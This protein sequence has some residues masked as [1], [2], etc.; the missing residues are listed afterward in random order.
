ME[1]NR[2]GID[3]ICYTYPGTTIPQIAS[4]VPHL[5][6]KHLVKEYQHIML[7]C[8]GNDA[9]EYCPSTIIKNYER[10]IKKVRD[11]APHARIHLS[12]IPPRRN[13]PNVLEKIAKINTYIKNR[14]KWNDN[15][16]CI[17]VCP[18][19]QQMYKTDRV[20]F[21]E[22]GTKMYGVN[23]ARAIVNFHRTAQKTRV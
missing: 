2:N 5:M 18:T 9:E 1:L 20:H 21:S 6:P 15:V 13:N 19:D 22:D 16:E 23:T 14:G 11:Q 7:Q 12:T 3:A 4:R 10:L 17:Q 8:G